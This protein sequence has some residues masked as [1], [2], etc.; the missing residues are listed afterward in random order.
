MSETLDNET[1]ESDNMRIN[2]YWSSLSEI[3]N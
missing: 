3:F 1:R 2:G